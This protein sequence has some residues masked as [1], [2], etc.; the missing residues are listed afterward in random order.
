M[1]KELNNVEAFCALENV[2]TVEDSHYQLLW[3]V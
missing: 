3:A 2:S 1:L